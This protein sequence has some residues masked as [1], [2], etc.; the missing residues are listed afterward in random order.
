MAIGITQE[1]AT[2]MALNLGFTGKNTAVVLIRYFDFKFC[3]VFLL[4]GHFCLKFKGCRA[5]C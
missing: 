3:L 2:K 5:N 4:K 1:Q